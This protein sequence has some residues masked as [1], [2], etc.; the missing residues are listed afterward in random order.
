[1]TYDRR[2]GHHDVMEKNE[3]GGGMSSFGCC[4]DRD[5]TISIAAGCGKRGQC[6]AKCRGNCVQLGRKL[7]TGTG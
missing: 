1:M 6:G 3:K 7:W 5:D 4:A 2:E